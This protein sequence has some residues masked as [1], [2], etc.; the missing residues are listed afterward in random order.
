MESD[1]AHKSTNLLTNA[2]ILIPKFV[3]VL[4]LNDAVDSNHPALR[5][6]LLN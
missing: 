4:K 5:A 1:C 3:I 6:P 2:R